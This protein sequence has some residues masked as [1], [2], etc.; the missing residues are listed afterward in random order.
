MLER[1]T[2]CLCRQPIPDFHLT[3]KFLFSVVAMLIL[4]HFF[5]VGSLLL[6][7]VKDIMWC[8]SFGQSTYAAY[9][10]RQWN[11]VEQFKYTN[12]LKLTLRFFSVI[13]FIFDFNEYSYFMRGKSYFTFNSWF[14]TQNA[15]YNWLFRF[16]H[17][18][19]HICVIQITDQPYSMQLI[20]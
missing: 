8:T 3:N 19:Q 14:R 11:R 4:F 9:Y 20:I 7:L 10:Q 6:S 1:Q 17:F 18:T 2:I 5:I 12:L 16:T 15:I 13:R